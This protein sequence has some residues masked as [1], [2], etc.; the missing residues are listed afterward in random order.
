MQV[1]RQINEE[2]APLFYGG[3]LFVFGGV[4]HLYAFLTHFAIRLPLVQ[5][6]GLVSGYTGYYDVRL[7]LISYILTY[8]RYHDLIL[9][10]G[11]K[12]LKKME[13]HSIFPLLASAT[14]LSAI[15]INPPVL[16]SLSSGPR[17]AAER[18][19]QQGHT[20]LT[21]MKFRKQDPLDVI[22]I[23]AVAYGPTKRSNP[24]WTGGKD[25]PGSFLHFFAAKLRS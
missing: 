24:L 16:Q 10:Q 2:A 25:V 23:T 22:N 21:A 1:C 13:L 6:I 20:W 3:N 15:Y 11:L 8:D 9:C 18:F 17:T 12:M 14:S 4:P 19:A 7:L 5:N